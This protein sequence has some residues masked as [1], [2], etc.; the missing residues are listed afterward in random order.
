M[1]L[2]KP[3]TIPDHQLLHHI[4]TGSYGEVWLAR[5]ATGLLRA[6]KIVRRSRFADDRPYEREFAGLRNFEPVSRGH[7]GLVDILQV[8]RNDAEGYF[9]YIMEAADDAVDLLVGNREATRKEESAPGSSASPPPPAGS[10]PASYRSLTLETCIRSQGRMPVQKCAAVGTALAEALQYLHAA[11]LVHRDLKPSNIIFVGGVPKLADVGLVARTD[12]ARSFV[13]TEGFVAP[14]G[15]GTIRADIYG[16][17]KV[18][19]EMAMGKDRLCFP[20]PATRLDELPERRELL[21]INEI[22]AKACDPSPDRRYANAAEMLRELRLL[23]T[24]CSVRSSRRWQQIRRGVLWMGTA[25]LILLTLVTCKHPWPQRLRDAG[26]VALPVTSAT[27]L[28][29]TGGF[30]IVFQSNSSGTDEIWT[31]KADG[32]AP[33]QLTSSSDPCEAPFVSPDGQSIAYTRITGRG[34]ELRVMDAEGGN[35]RLILEFRGSHPS[36]VLNGFFPDGKALLYTA[37]HTDIAR[38]GSTEVWT[39]DLASTNQALFID[40]SLV[41]GGNIMRMRL[42]AFGTRVAWTVQPGNWSPK[43]EVY[44]ADYIN[45]QVV[46]STITRVTWDDDH[47]DTVVLSPDGMRLAFSKSGNATHYDPPYQAFV[48]WL[49]RLE[50]PQSTNHMNHPAHRLEIVVWDLALT[51]WAPGRRILFDA[52]R[53]P[54]QGLQRQVYSIADDGSD[55]TQITRDR[56]DCRTARWRFRGN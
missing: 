56:I 25:G 6:V 46:P 3:L 16:L 53:T 5:N 37:V 43:V 51:D 38:P 47:E 41:Q 23:G 48:A 45:R 8:G 7:P 15:P 50:G 55:L 27:S 11:G 54:D 13:G 49:G 28:A 40:P 21:E 9:F 44:A 32:T 24:T 14:E 42:S 34:R 36:P 35:D 39:V 31:M 1:S 52:T 22:I 2:S 4:G 20:S 12:S 33:Q 18:L 26:P 17:G 10:E 29:E 19:Y 30:D